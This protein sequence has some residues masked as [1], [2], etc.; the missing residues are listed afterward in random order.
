MRVAAGHVCPSITANSKREMALLATIRTRGL[1]LLR[2]HRDGRALRLTGPNV[3]ILVT[4]LASLTLDDLNP[5]T[6]TN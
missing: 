1:T 4:D 6:Q 3:H 2:C 5:P